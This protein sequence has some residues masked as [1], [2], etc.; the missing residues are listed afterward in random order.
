MQ[1]KIKKPR[2]KARILVS[3]E[4]FAEFG[5]RK[6]KVRS[7]QRGAQKRSGKSP[8]RMQDIYKKHPPKI[9]SA[10]KPHL[11]FLK[12]GKPE[13]IVLIRAVIEAAKKNGIGTASEIS[14]ILNKMLIKTA[15]GEKW[16]PRL[17]WFAAAAVKAHNLP[18]EVR[19][20]GRSI[21]KQ[22]RTETKFRDM[23]NRVVKSR[24]KE[25]SS[26]IEAST[27]TLGEALPELA[28]LK[29][30]LEGSDE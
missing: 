12:Y 17:A 27:P 3:G 15:I 7:M 28:A 1:A 14:R 10:D 4:D 6:A 29:R 20:P 8:I 2:S 5:M 18:H 30:R 24:F 19:A 23:V 9:A 21:E 16:T 11:D 22:S 26:E 25:I 13:Q